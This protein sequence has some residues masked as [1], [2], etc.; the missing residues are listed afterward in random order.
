MLEKITLHALAATHLDL[1]AEEKYLLMRAA[2]LFGFETVA[3]PMPQLEVVIGMTDGVL[4]RARDSLVAKQLLVEVEGH[5]GGGGGVT[6]P[7][8]QPK[9][10][11]LSDRCPDILRGVDG[12][13]RRIERERR[14]LRLKASTHLTNITSLVAWGASKGH[15]KDLLQAALLRGASAPKQVPPR[16]VTRVLLATLFGM[17]DERGVVRG[18]GLGELS[19]LAGM[20]RQSLE[21]QLSKLTE[22]GYLRSYVP[23][24]TGTTLFG[25]SAGAIF[26]NLSHPGLA[27]PRN[28]LLVCLQTAFLVEHDPLFVGHRIYQ[29]AAIRRHRMSRQASGEALP[30]LRTIAETVGA[31]REWLT[32]QQGLEPVPCFIPENLNRP[33]GLMGG[34]SVMVLESLWEE[35]ELHQIFRDRQGEFPR[36]L[37]AKVEEYASTLLSASWDDLDRGGLLPQK[38]L[39]WIRRDLLPESVLVNP[40]HACFR[41]DARAEALSLFVYVLALRMAYW[42]KAV[43]VHDLPQKDWQGLSPTSSLIT[44]LPAAS[45]HDSEGRGHMA[46]SILPRLSGQL[47]SSR[48][49]G[50]VRQPIPSIRRM[51]EPT[52]T[53][54]K[55]VT[56]AAYWLEAFGIKDS[57]KRKKV[58]P[59]RSL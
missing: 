52:V 29:Q 30:R 36:Y 35:G 11:R 56:P 2:H 4:K 21:Y 3:L 44:V 16:Y 58:K 50:L 34:R 14:V 43:L 13:Q 33:N 55:E 31:T 40:E 45:I 53:Y 17:A 37:Q 1:S 9:S 6:T 12:D 19:R 38:L 23:G 57:L 42:V 18:I 24:V 39:S 27:A 47:N 49:V 7:G 25:K 32:L 46:I 59:V 51:A 28:E 5:S 48:V 15:G 26:L 22:E 10:F 8:R 41:D 54:D 20:E